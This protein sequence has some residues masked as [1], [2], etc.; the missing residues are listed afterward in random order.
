MAVTLQIEEQ[1]H[2]LTEAEGEA[3]EDDWIPWENMTWMTAAPSE[4]T[5]PGG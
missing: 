1:I 4:R 2:R 3:K 5:A